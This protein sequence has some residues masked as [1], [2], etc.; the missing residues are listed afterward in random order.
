MPAE[1]RFHA[2]ALAF[3]GF[4]KL[5]FLPLTALAQPFRR[6]LGDELGALLEL[7]QKILH[8]LGGC[9]EQPIV[10]PLAGRAGRLQGRLQAFQGACLRFL[11]IRLDGPRTA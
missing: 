5:P 11:R 6:A 8:I 2:L 7:R 1:L 9:F 3:Q 4:A 10:D